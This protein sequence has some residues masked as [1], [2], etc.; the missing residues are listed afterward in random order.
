MALARRAFAIEQCDVLLQR[1]MIH[2]GYEDR[3][4]SMQSARNNRFDEAQRSRGAAQPE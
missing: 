3:V 1:P 4:C 2:A